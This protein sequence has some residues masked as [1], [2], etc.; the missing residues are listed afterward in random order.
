MLS[1]ISLLYFLELDQEVLILFVLEDQVVVVEEGLELV[2]A[3]AAAA[4]A[5]VDPMP[6]EMDLVES[7]DNLP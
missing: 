4:A 6:V 2:L 1:K 3:S 7:E 5:G